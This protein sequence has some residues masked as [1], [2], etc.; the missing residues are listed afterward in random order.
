MAKSVD[1]TDLKSVG[2][3]HAGSI[4]AECTNYANVPI[5]L[6]LSDTLYLEMCSLEG[7]IAQ[8]DGTVKKTYEYQLKYMA[9]N[10]GE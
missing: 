2:A 4:P 6:K 7:G 5:Y 8:R 9:L 1:A 10:D 3:T